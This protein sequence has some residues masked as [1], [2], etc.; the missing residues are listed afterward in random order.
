[1][2]TNKKEWRLVDICG[3]LCFEFEAGS[4]RAAEDY[5]RHHLPR[6][7]VKAELRAMLVEPM[8]VDIYMYP[9]NTDKSPKIQQQMQNKYFVDLDEFWTNQEY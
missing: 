5:V 4:Q 3:D 7:A 9:L 2:K 1:M 8:S 6:N